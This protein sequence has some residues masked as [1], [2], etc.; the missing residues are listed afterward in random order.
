MS[1][2]KQKF[3]ELFPMYKA[4]ADAFGKALL[5]VFE[6]GYAAGAAA[7]R[8]IPSGLQEGLYIGIIE[9]EAGWGTKHDGY[10]VGLTLADMDARR[11]EFESGNTSSYGLYFEKGVSYTPVKL[12][13]SAI[14]LILEKGNPVWF[15]N[16]SDFM[17]GAE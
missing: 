2:V 5:E 8:A 1:K 16:L 6:K 4:D 13:E 12:K 7:Q 17:E 15:D 11:K 9:A 14:A 10:M 3:E